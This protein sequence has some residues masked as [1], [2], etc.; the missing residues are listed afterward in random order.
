MLANAAVTAAKDKTKMEVTSFPCFIFIS[1]PKRGLIDS[2]Y[3]SKPCKTKT[4]PILSK[5]R[6]NISRF[7]WTNGNAR[8]FSFKAKKYYGNFQT[9]FYQKI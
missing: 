5:D 6:A 1:S 9:L 2:V 8:P 4:N 7:I 3:D